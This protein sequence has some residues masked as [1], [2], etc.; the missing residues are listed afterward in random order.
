[1]KKNKALSPELVEFAANMLKCVGHPIRLRIVELL[2]AQGELPVNQLQEE[3]ELVQPVVSQHLTK[4]KS[5]GLL[6]A[7][8]RQG[9]VFYSVALPQLFKLLECIRG[10]DP[11]YRQGPLRAISGS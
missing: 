7:Q 6:R 11:A 4:M 5:L 3:L 1:M 8:R 9:M 10:C 2:E